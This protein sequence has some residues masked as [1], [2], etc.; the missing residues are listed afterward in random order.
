MKSFE[1]FVE[2]YRETN[3]FLLPLVNYS[4]KPLSDK[5]LE[6]KYKEYCKKVEKQNEKKE[7]KI[8]NG[9][10]KMYES[11]LNPTDNKS[12]HCKNIDKTMQ[13][14]HENN[15]ISCYRRFYNSLE[16]WQKKIIDDNMWLCPKKN[17]VYTFDGCHIL[18]R[19]KYSKLADD[20]D[21]IVLLPRY[22]HKCL[23]DYINPFT[24]KIM[25]KEE[26]D[27]VWIC[28]VGEER[29]NRLHEKTLR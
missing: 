10:I 2:Y 22:L 26:H 27:D 8:I 28:I 19:G 25:K 15:D 11:M 7:E 17:G 6:S 16:Y 13:K 4:K 23:D 21:N 9:K 3:R 14:V 18:D 20:E 29:W 12:E 5:Q 24:Q 1:E